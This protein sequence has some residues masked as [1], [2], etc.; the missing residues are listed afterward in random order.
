MKRYLLRSAIYL[1]AIACALAIVVC[2][3][4]VWVFNELV[5]YG[6]SRLYPGYSTM[7]TIDSREARLTFLV[8]DPVSAEEL[9][10]EPTRWKWTWY[11][12]LAKDDRAQ[13]R[14]T[15]REL[16]VHCWVARNRDI[17]HDAATSPGMLRGGT[18][19]VN[20]P[21]WLLTLLGALGPAYWAVRARVRERRRIRLASRGLCAECGYNLRG[22][23][24]RCPECGT[25]AP[26]ITSTAGATSTDVPPIECP[27][28]SGN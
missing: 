6:P 14:W 20:V 22:T 19:F 25:V 8:M 21:Y 5:T 12:W 10:E 17:P 13:E 9:G 1:S 16:W 18:V 24:A 26:P 3:R 28:S 2:I 27:K 23:L 7:W 15:I 11:G 4:S